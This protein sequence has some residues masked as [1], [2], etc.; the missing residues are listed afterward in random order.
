MP[1]MNEGG[2]G[3]EPKVAKIDVG[4]ARGNGF[5]F[6]IAVR[7]GDL[8]LDKSTG[9]YVPAPGG[10]LFTGWK[11]LTAKE[12]AL[13]RREGYGSLVV[14]L[15][16]PYDE[17]A[18]PYA[19]RRRAVPVVHAKGGDA[20]FVLS[21]TRASTGAAVRREPFATV[22]D[23]LKW[24]DDENARRFGP[25]SSHDF[26][27]PIRFEGVPYGIDESAGGRAS[28]GSARNAF[29]RRP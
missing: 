13:F 21:Y 28:R 11:Y 17:P 12:A 19:Y 4:R 8:R 2:A 25:W 10:N 3:R 18:K 6:T 9:R 22:A 26:V 23:G 29:L 16:E 27:E 15:K 5:P 24:I 14:A 7:V 20:S 1:A